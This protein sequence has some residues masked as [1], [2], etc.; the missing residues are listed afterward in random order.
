MIV[1]RR[2][3]GRLL[4]DLDIGH[5]VLGEEALLL[6]DDERRGV[7]Q[8]DVAEDRLRY[9]RRLCGVSAGNTVGKHKLRRSQRRC[10]R[11]GRLQ[12][13]PARQGHLPRVFDAGRHGLD[14]SWP[15]KKPHSKGP[16]R[17]G[18]SRAATLP[19][20][21]PALGRLRPIPEHSTQERKSRAK[22]RTW[23]NSRILRQDCVNEASRT[24]GCCLFLQRRLFFVQCKKAKG[25]V[26]PCVRRDR[27]RTR[28]A[29]LRQGPAQRQ[30]A[31]N[32]PFANRTNPPG[33]DR[34]TPFAPR[35]G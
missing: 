7:G 29:R 25:R 20:Y 11:S 34:A 15:K 35:Q 33:P 27:R 31:P 18:R 5:A 14:P 12:K 8:R 4:G 6:G 22:R 26:R 21:G 9:L 30:P 2:A 10:R 32:G 1:A 28:T 19:I 24:G 3:P 23:R 16:G 13:S 17:T